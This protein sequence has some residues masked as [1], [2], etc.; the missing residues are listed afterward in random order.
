[1][2]KGLEGLVRLPQLR[3][4]PADLDVELFV[5]LPDLVGENTVGFE[6]VTA[7]SAQVRDDNAFEGEERYPRR[8]EDRPHTERH[9]RFDKEIVAYDN[10][11]QRREE[12]WPKAA[13]PRGHCHA[14][15]EG[16]HWR[17]GGK[18]RVE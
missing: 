1:M 10:A 7:L 18:N 13:V 4:P 2:H 9:P 8:V 16:K 6:G 15:D 3:R 11:Q 12:T 17:L 14:H 5:V